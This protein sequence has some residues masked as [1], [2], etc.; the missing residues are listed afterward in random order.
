MIRH[1]V[2]RDRARTCNSVNGYGIFGC[3]MAMAF[4]YWQ[5]GDMYLGYLNAYPEYPTQGQTLDEL[6]SMLNDIYG[7]IRDGDLADIAATRHS[8]ILETPF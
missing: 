6:K 8:D 2:A 1:I 5:D 4:T 3:V 7:A